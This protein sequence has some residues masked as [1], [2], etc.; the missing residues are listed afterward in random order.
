MKLA[1]LAAAFVLATTSAA[2]L[3]DDHSKQAEAAAKP[4]IDMSIEQLVADERSKAILE[5]HLPGISAHPSYGQ[6]KGM[7]L[8]QLQPWSGGMI[9]DE[10]IS[11]IKADLEA[12]EQE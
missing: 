7:T 12:I 3:A 1:P 4:S 5:K 9:T 2:A 8:V 6:F 10:G 11:K